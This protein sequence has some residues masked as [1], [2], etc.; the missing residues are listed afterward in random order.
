MSIFLIPKSFNACWINNKSNN[1][2]LTLSKCGMRTM[3]KINCCCLKMLQARIYCLFPPLTLLHPL[4]V[5]CVC[6]C[7]CV[8]LDVSDSATP[9]TVA[10]Q[11]PLCMGFLRQEY[12]RGL[13]F[14]T[15]GDLSDPRIE[16]TSLGSPALAGRFF[17]TVPPG[18]PSIT[19][20][21]IQYYIKKKWS[22]V[23]SCRKKAEN[24][25]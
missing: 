18:M 25:R 3:E 12:W 19:L 21:N 7:V 1:N 17:T 11:A 8:H 23:L 6:A 15:P 5:H 22:K 10:Q 4:I 13:P 14:P 16:P 24:C 9:W 20:G 2:I